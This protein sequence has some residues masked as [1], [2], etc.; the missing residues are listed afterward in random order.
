MTITYIV[1][2]KTLSK[3]KQKARELKKSAGIPHHEALEQVAKNIG[4][5]NWHKM[6]KSA[7]ITAQTESA[8]LSGLIVAFDIKDGGS[9]DP[10]DT[11]VEDD[12]A[13]EFCEKDLV[14]SYRQ[15]CEDEGEPAT[16]EE[17]EE[18][19]QFEVGN[20]VFFRYVGKDSPQNVRE[21][22]N[23]VN[24][25]SFWPPL[26]VWLNGKFNET[27]NENATSDDGE[28]VGVRF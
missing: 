22:L 19:R 26:Y 12:Q 18:Y 20:H 10:A 7:E 1:S 28:V 8:F 15:A 14:A 11:F 24:A 21:A 6:A 23:I 3:F 25:Q 13:I 2:S 4:L 16:E 5:P 9:F 27:Y 17:V